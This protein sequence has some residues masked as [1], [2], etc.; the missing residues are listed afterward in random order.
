M[1][2]DLDTGIE[3]ALRVSVQAGLTT[4]INFDM[5]LASFK[6]KNKVLDNPIRLKTPKKS[7]H[8]KYS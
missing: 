8:F 1:A 5:D 4:D 3:Q 7:Y 6:I 2:G